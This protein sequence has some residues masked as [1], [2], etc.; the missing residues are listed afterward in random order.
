M[1]SYNK[2]RWAISFWESRSGHTDQF[3]T[4][5]LSPSFHMAATTL[6]GNTFDAFS[7]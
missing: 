3:V 6:L 2:F 1:L 5:P 7:G 4:L